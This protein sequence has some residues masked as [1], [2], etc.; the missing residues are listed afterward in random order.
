[1]APSSEPQTSGRKTFSRVRLR[2]DSLV[3]A[4]ISSVWGTAAAPLVFFDVDPVYRAPIAL[5]FALLCPGLALVR[6]FG[7]PGILAKLL[8]GV[9]ISLALDVLIPAMLLYSGVWSP[10]MAFAILVGITGVAAILE[11]VRGPLR[12]SFVPN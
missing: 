2:R 11:V 12:T 6:L 5:G 10:S 3:W 1:M 4:T 9:A 7:I 8:L